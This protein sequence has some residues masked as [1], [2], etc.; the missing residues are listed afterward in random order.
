MDS[1]QRKR[2]I[3][4]MMSNWRVKQGNTS[5]HCTIYTDWSKHGQ[6]YVLLNDQNQPVLWNSKRNSEVE[7]RYLSEL[8]ET[9]AAVWALSE[10]IS[11]WRSAPI[12]ICS[13]SKDF[14]L[15][16]QNAQRATD[17]RLLINARNMGLSPIFASFFAYRNDIE[18]N[19]SLTGCLT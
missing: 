10:T 8:G 14:L 4:T 5:R 19:F 3:L 16:Y 17:P 13:G 15:I 7:A 6:G 12:Q 9:T 11:F 1:R 2:D 18:S